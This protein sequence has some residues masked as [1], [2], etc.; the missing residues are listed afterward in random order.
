MIGARAATVRLLIFAALVALCTAVVITA[1]RPAAP[2]ARDGHDAIF[3]DVSGLF[4]GDDVRMAGVLVGKVESVRLDGTRARVRFTVGRDHDLFDNTQAAVRYQTL[5]GQRYVELIRPGVPGR[6]LPPGATIP[7]ER[8]IPSFDI[9]KLF[10]G[11]TPLFNALDPAQLN[12]FA[13]HVLQVLQGDGSGIGPVLA[14]IEALTA[15]ARSREAVIVLLIR[16]LD[17]ISRQIAGKSTLVGD[18]IEQLGGVLDRFASRSHEIVEATATA[19]KVLYP[20]VDLLEGLR[21]TYDTGYA[22]MDAMVRRLLPRT[23]QLVEL[24][25]LVPSLLGNLNRRIPANG[26][27]YTCADGSQDIPGIGTIVLGNQR[28]VVCK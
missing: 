20:A 21:S 19:N 16:N 7:I 9:S 22:P 23:G 26:Q 8:T 17:E 15:F 14:D 13:E 27:T 10:N 3:T 11:F 24:L 6:P 18:L 28:L 5:I 2:G 12:R 25:G 4:A 1:L